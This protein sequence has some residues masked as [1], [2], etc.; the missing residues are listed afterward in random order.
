MKNNEQNKIEIFQSKD[1][2][3][4]VTVMFEKETVWLTQKLMADLFQVKPQNITMHLRNIF[5]EGE[6]KKESTCKDF[7]QVQKEGSREVKR[8][9][10]FYNLDA[11]ISVGYRIKSQIATQFRQ[12][13]TNRLKDYLVKGYAIN[14]KRLEQK[15]QEVLHLKTGIQILSRAIEEKNDFENNEILNIFAKGLELL[16]NYDHEKLDTKGKTKQETI[17]PSYK[18]YIGFITEMYSEFE[19]AVFAKPKDDSFHSS[20]NLIQQTFDGK[21][22]YPSIQEKASN[23]LYSIVKNHSFVDGN[24]RIAAACFLYFLDKNKALF[25]SNNKTIISNNTLA[26]LTLFIATSKSNEADIVKQL[27]ISILNRNDDNK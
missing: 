13:A 25:N 8:N 4:V 15:N 9:Q 17:F 14:E 23:L 3:T 11:I 18:D 12:W 6:L 20:I 16:D 7:L 27:V 19:S 5:A 10:K 26:S 21:E 22:L 24:K 1:S 2:K